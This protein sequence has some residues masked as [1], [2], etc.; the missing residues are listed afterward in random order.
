METTLKLTEAQIAVLR[1]IMKDFAE[2][3]PEDQAAV[4]QGALPGYTLAHAHAV[5]M[6]VAEA[7]EWDD[8]ASW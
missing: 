6:D 7:V 3:A 2:R 5:W 4:L 8:H 1:A